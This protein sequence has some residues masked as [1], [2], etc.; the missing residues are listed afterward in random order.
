MLS[1]SAW[2]QSLPR[3]NK[4]VANVFS[5]GFQA[6]VPRRGRALSPVWLAN[7]WTEMELAKQRMDT[8]AGVDLDASRSLSGF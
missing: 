5:E 8:I 6:T 7:E 3:H 1:C 2:H 4:H